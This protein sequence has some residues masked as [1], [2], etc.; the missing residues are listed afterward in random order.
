MDYNRAKE[1]DTGIQM[2]WLLHIYIHTDTQIH[3]HI[4]IHSDTHKAE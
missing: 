1:I 4:H 3:S 2:G